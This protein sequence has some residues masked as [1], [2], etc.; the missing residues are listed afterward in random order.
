MPWT[1]RIT[2]SAERQLEALGKPAAQRIRDFLHDR[3]EGNTSPY[4]IAKALVGNKQGFFRFRVGDYRIVAE[5]RQ[6][7]LLVLVVQAGHRKDIYD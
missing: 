4:R 5:L 6:D 3:V 2:R 7:E 1:V